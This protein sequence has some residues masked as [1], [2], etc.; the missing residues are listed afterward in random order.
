MDYPCAELGDF[1]FSRF[2]FIVRTDRLTYS[3]RCMNVV[4]VHE[5]RLLE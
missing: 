1:N 3:Q 4:N 5:Y 2:G